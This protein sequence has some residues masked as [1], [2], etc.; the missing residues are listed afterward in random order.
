MRVNFAQFLL[1][2][3]FPGDKS[4]VVITGSTCETPEPT[5]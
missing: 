3:V 2:I 5:L 1:K 4:T